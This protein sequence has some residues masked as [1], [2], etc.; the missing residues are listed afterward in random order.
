MVFVV[1]DDFDVREV[2]KSLPELVGLRAEVFGS[3]REF[4]QNKPMDTVSCLVLDVSLPGVSG[5][6]FQAELAGTHAD[7]PIIFLSGH[8]DERMS[9]RAMKAGAVEFLTKPVREQDLFDAIN[10]AFERDRRRANEEMA[11]ALSARF[12]LLS[13]CEREVVSLVITGML[14]KQIAGEMKLS[15][16]TV[17]VHRDKLMEKLGAKSLLELVRMVNVLQLPR[18]GSSADHRRTSPP[19][20]WPIR[21]TTA[22]RESLA[23][24][25][26]PVPTSPE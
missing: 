5:L 19:R 11:R 18:A 3:T 17:K 4:L 12:Q 20:D 25:I 6:D 9:V 23:R 7:I 16:A 22:L 10:V 13:D 2:L 8:G 15:E 14:N 26:R 1:D 24:F 21:P